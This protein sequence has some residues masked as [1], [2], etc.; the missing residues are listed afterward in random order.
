MWD[1]DRMRVINADNALKNA[2]A[3]LEEVSEGLKKDEPLLDFIT[4]MELSGRELHNQIGSA[5]WLDSLLDAFK[6]L[7]KGEDPTQ[8]LVEH[9]DV[10]E[11]INWLISLEPRRP[12]L[13]SRGKPIVLERKAKSI[14]QRPTLYG[15]KETSLGAR[16]GFSLSEPLD[17]GLLKREVL[18]LAYS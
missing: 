3:W 15:I 6:Q 9:P 10:R 7:R 12:L 4:R 17:T 5:A 11:D 2:Q 14:Y 16:T 13:S 1:P 18:L 8:V